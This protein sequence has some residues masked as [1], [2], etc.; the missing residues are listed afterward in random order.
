MTYVVKNFEP[1]LWTVGHYQP[2]GTFD[3]DSDHRNQDR[4]AERCH[5][6]NGGSDVAALV[7]D[8]R[9]QLAAANDTARDLRALV[10]EILDDSWPSPRFEG[11]SEGLRAHQAR[12]DGWRERAG[13]ERQS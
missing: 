1:R 2:D 13:L 12:V 8:W 4:A 11:I 9:T 5:F 10:A 7:D 3:P 6:L